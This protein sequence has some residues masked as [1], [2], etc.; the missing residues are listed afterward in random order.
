MSKI[1]KAL[2]KA[3]RERVRGSLDAT[4]VVSKSATMTLEAPGGIGSVAS[5]GAIQVDAHI[6]CASDSGSPIAEQYRALR[7]NLQSLISRGGPRVIGVTSAVH[8]EGKTVTAVNL[9]FTM[10]RQDKS[11]VV[12]VDADLRRGSIHKWL[13]LQEH[14]HGLASA[15]LQDGYLNG[16]LVKLQKT[17]LTILPS[18]PNVDHPADLLASSA[19]RRVIATL[20]TRFDMIIIDMPP[21]LAVS[22]P[23]II[24][25]QTDGFLLVVRAGSTQRKM[26]EKTKDIL[27]QAKAKLLGCVLTY[28]EY[29]AE[30]Y[31][32][33]QAYYQRAN[34]EQN[35][36]RVSQQRPEIKRL[37][38]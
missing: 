35:G 1:T 30:Q 2:E 19:M 29:E 9:A 22:D 27:T 17:A 13:G 33:Y 28:A 20:K 16:S 24:A 14:K 31:Y 10:A 34:E 8:S 21:V 7:T 25:A 4:T 12:L 38:S 18:G 6:V 37:P 11:R 23:G 26:V 32:R 36:G 15:L 5:A 3:A